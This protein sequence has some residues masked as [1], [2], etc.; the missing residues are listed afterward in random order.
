MTCKKRT[1]E[2][3]KLAKQSTES[4]AHIKVANTN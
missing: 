4:S 2:N 3:K 1:A